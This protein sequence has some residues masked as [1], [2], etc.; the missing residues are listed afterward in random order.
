MGDVASALLRR[1]TQPRRDAGR[2]TVVKIVVANSV[3]RLD[4]NQEVILFP[5]RWDSAVP[6]R[7]PFAYY[8]YELAY[9]STLLKRET[10]HQVKM[11]DGNLSLLGADDYA[12]AIAEE[13]PDILATE[14][15]ALTYPAMTRAMLKVKEA[16]GCHAMLCGPLGT[17]DKQRAYADGWDAVIAGEFEHKVLNAIQGKQPPQGYID[18]DWLPLPEDQDITRIL[19]TEA[20]NPIDGLIQV[21]PT[22]GCPLAC[23]FCVVPLYYG[24]H[25]NSHKS[26]RQR[27]PELVCDEIEYLADMYGDDFNGC[28]FNE[29]AHNANVEWLT[30]FAETLIRRKLNQ[31]EYDAM[32][33][34]WTFTEP[35][36]NLLAGAGYSQIRF[37]VESTSQVV[38]KAIHKTMHLDR[39]ERFMG[40]CREAGI[41]CY[42][43]FQ[44]G[45]PGA[46]EETDRQTL[47]DLARWVQS[48]LMSRWQVSTSTPQPGTPFYREAQENGWLLTEDLSRFDGERAVVSYPDYPA[49]RIELVKRGG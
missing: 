27:N 20:S 23:T 11:L 33:G 9:L 40:W 8:P 31:Y 13:E 16:R 25:G 12:N 28:F 7:R 10:D 15:S 32:C 45:A 47:R 24:S 42:G 19:Y 30:R 14:C 36:V 34:Y 38:G 48:G 5:S 29:E 43:T 46:S 39:L 49:D 2:A 18:L 4:N 17:Y 41:E 35:L 6:G 22:R 37:G 44:I 1:E 21:Y 3:G 26:H